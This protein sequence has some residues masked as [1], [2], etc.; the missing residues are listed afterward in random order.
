LNYIEAESEKIIIRKLIDEIDNQRQRLKKSIKDDKL[1]EKYK[2]SLSSLI[3]SKDEWKDANVFEDTCE[4][5]HYMKF[6]AQHCGKFPKKIRTILFDVLFSFISDGRRAAGGTIG[7]Y[8]AN[9]LRSMSKYISETNVR[10][11]LKTF[12]VWLNTDDVESVNDAA[13]G[14]S[15]FRNWIDIN[16][17]S[18]YA[19][20]IKTII[21]SYPE[22]FIGPDLARSYLSIC[23]RN[24]LDREIL[25]KI[26]KVAK[27]IKYIGI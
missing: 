2:K 20:K 12:D 5:D 18:T 27:Y 17:R 26:N 16:Q 15:V 25:S 11:L 23:E 14:I 8:A 6:L 1:L 7:G 22:Y 4:T 19:Q 21:L 3:F 24:K 9:A 10:K 13:Y